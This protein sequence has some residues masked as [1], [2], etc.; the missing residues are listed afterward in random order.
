MSAGDFTECLQV[1]EKARQESI[2]VPY[3]NRWSQPDTIVPNPTNPQSLNRY[4]YVFNNPVNLVDPTGHDGKCL[5]YLDDQCVVYQTNGGGTTAQA[6]STTLTTQEEQMLEEELK[7]E[8]CGQGGP[9]LDIC[10]E[11]PDDLPDTNT[12]DVYP[13][14]P[15]CRRVSAQPGEC[16]VNM[17]CEPSSICNLNMTCDPSLLQFTEYPLYFPATYLPEW[18]IYYDASQIDWLGLGID[19]FGI[20]GDIALGLNPIIGAPIWFASEIPEFLTIG[21]DFDALD[22]QEG[23]SVVSVLLGLGTTLAQE[24]KLVPEVG[25]LGNAV[26]I[27]DN[28]GVAPWEVRYNWRP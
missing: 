22:M 8:V 7:T 10:F 13:D 24:L 2:Y 5:R 27:L 25:S 20:G 19:V 4:S 23:D 14:L 11:E 26:S 21:S 17:S 28:I 1:R 16:F 18:T 3:L 15:G 6:P 9:Q 12:C